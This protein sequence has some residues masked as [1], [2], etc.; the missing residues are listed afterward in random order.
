MFGCMTK[1]FTIG[2]Y[3]EYQRLAAVYL[4]SENYC[5]Y[6]ISQCRYD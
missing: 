2:S 6:Y 1:D 4:A 5:I 3:N